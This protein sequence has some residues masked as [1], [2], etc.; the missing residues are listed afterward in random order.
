MAQISLIDIDHLDEVLQRSQSELSAE[1]VH[2]IACGMLAV[3]GSVDPDPLVKHVVEDFDAHNLAHSEAAKLLQSLLRQITTQ[4]NDVELDFQ[5]LLPD[6]DESMDLRVDALS[7][8][9][10][11]FLLG[12]GMGGLKDDTDL[13]ETV[14]EMITDLIEIAR[15]SIEDDIEDELE[16]NFFEVVEYVR[17]GVL[18]IHEELN[19]V[20]SSTLTSTRIQ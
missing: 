16:N 14:S 17:V 15:I 2:G 8:W 11:G 6:D 13:P 19:P 18:L 3:L 1:E 10:Q 9:C 4:F 20:D 12:V 5:L 7:E